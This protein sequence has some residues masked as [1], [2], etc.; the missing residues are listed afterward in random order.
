MLG[1]GQGEASE[2]Y[3]TEPDTDEE[4]RQEPG[5][6]FAPYTSEL[7]SENVI[8]LPP[9][10]EQTNTNDSSQP[11]SQECFPEPSEI[12]GENN[13]GLKASEQGANPA[14]APIW[15]PVDRTIQ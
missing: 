6:E 4:S 13:I 3:L 7:S 11:S 1:W 12:N 15:K 2:L 10:S 5:Q 8:P 14:M 9:V